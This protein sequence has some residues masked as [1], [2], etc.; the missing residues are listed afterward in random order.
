MD[1]ATRSAVL[2]EGRS[3]VVFVAL[4]GGVGGSTRSLAN[5]LTYLDGCVTR[6][7]AGPPSGRF[8]SYVDELG[9]AELHL[10]AVDNTSR[11]GV[12][13]RARTA[14]ALAR[15]VWPRRRQVRALFA[16]GLEEL[17]VCLPVARAARLPVVVWVHNFDL[18]R[19]A[20]MLQRLW[21]VVGRGATVRWAAVSSLAHVL[22][23]DAGFVA[24]DDVVIVPNP[25]DPADILAKHRISN[26]PPT[27]AFLGTP[28]EY[29][30]FQFLPGLIERTVTP[31]GMP[32][33][34]RWLIFSRQTDETK[35]AGTWDRLRTLEQEGRV[36]IMGKLTNVSEAYAQCDVVVCPSVMESFCRVAAEAMLNGIPVVGSDLE[37][38]RA[39]LGRR[40]G[41]PGEA[42]L[43][44]PVGDI[45]AGAAAIARLARDP[46]LRRR[47]GGEGRRRAADYGPEGV[48]AAIRG[49]L[50][51]STVPE[52]DGVFRSATGSVP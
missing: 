3:A 9:A 39:L 48:G 31:D 11:V 41:T 4:A 35:L 46:G 26:D 17:A 2:P 29:K 15:W 30:G 37:P 51:V 13:R 6:V 10:P 25:I 34:L 33:S 47:L 12:V 18:S 27:V 52:S 44:F 22:V 42:G 38:V 5:V 28:V 49:L 14:A 50:G 16:N 1:R 32:G 19:A 20:R 23:V 36:S 45:D 7:L 43:L 8:V 21:P 40:D 24:A